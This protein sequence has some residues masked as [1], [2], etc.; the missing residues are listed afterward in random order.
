M[1]FQLC[2]LIQEIPGTF[3][4]GQSVGTDL[5]SPNWP[6][7]IKKNPHT[8]VGF[9]NYSLPGFNQAFLILRLR[10]K[11]ARPSPIN[12]RVIGSG[13]CLTVMTLINSWSYPLS[14]R[15]ILK[16]TDITSYE[17]PYR[18]VFRSSLHTPK[19]ALFAPRF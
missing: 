6:V 9:L 17:P 3:S 13:T 19:A 1:G 2:L 16:S 5:L 10:P 11:P 18:A 4:R 7:P 15:A 8:I 12:A 14:I